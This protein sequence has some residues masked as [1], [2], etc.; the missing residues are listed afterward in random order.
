MRVIIL[1][2]IGRDAALLASTLAA[3]EIDS[4]I[5][6][7]ANEL[8]AL[9]AE[10]VGGAIL[11]D[12]ALPKCAIQGLAAWVS[13]LPPWSDPPFIVLTS[14]GIPTRQTHQRAQELQALGNVTLIERPVRPD[15]I[16]LAARSALRA[17]MR[18]YEV[19]SRQEALIQANADLE[20]FAH[21]A[22]HDF[23][24]PLR[25]IGISTDLLALEYADSVDERAGELLR[26]IRGGV[27]RMEALLNDLL[28]YA[29]ASSITE[30]ELPP[31]PALRSVKVAVENLD[32]AIRESQANI[33]IGELP[34][35][36]VRESHLAQV[37]QNLLGNA[38]KYRRDDQAPAIEVQA[39]RVN[40]YWH[41]TIADNGIGIPAA[42]QGAIFG[43]FK[44]LHGHGK[45][46]GTGMGLA[47][48]KRIVERYRGNIW[49]E[50][51]PGH[52][53]RFSFS[54]PA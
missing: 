12:E 20:Q 51:E 47:I 45:Y 34:E 26:L 23:R 24:E 27:A 2:P 4:A 41:F 54:I 37:F 48:C 33:T 36:R 5:A 52:G 44:R 49:V 18:Q 3:S 39:K 28:S 13:E 46:S 32:A 38:I 22:S 35:I 53:C 30:E 17:R 1:A 14:S 9:L 6:T 15:T 50:S 8:L 10:G 19:R 29:H 25:S 7:D 11:A 42:Y 16:R 31:V 40:S 21:S 43:I